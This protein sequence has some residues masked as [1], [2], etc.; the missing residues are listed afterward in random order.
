MKY[1]HLSLRWAG[2]FK[3]G[4]QN[5]SSVTNGL[6]NSG[7]TTTHVSAY[8]P[9]PANIHCLLSDIHVGLHYSSQCKPTNAVSLPCDFFH[10]ALYQNVAL[11]TACNRVLLENLTLVSASQEIS[12]ILWNLK[13]QHCIYKSL[14]PVH[15]LSQINPV[16]ATPSHFLKIHLIILPSMLYLP[17]RLIPLGFPTKTLCTP[18]SPAPYVPHGPS[19]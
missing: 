17:S 6:T 9:R 5:S 1:Y 14:L 4:F 16:H 18:L 12:H 7:Q 11:L 3:R 2:K 13:V 8:Q 19:I 15:I 10:L